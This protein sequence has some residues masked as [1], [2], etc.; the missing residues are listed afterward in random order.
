MAHKPFSPRPFPPPALAGVP[1]EYIV[2]QLHTLAHR[3]W[4]RPETADCVLIVPTCNHVQSPPSPP[5]TSNTIP[6]LT[7]QLHIDYLSAKSSLIRGLFSGVSPLER[8]PSM[9]SSSAPSGS[10]VPRLLDSCSSRPVLLLPVPDPRSIH[11]LIHWIYFGKTD[12]IEACLKGGV[13][14]WEGLARNAEYLGLSS[15]IKVFLGR[16]YGKWLLPARGQLERCSHRSEDDSDDDSD[17][18]LEYGEN[19][20]EETSE[21]VV[22]AASNSRTPDVTVVERGRSRIVCPLT[23]LPGNLKVYAAA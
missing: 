11:L 16:W 15:D 10:P 2:E 1:L 14:N 17:I 20:V 19:E 6:H 21:D 3:Y 18:E 4:N 22:C 9:Q 12:H 23:R 13:V 8:S 5:A 7:L